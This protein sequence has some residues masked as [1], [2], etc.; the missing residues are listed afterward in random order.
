MN[1]CVCV[2]AI[3][4]SSVYMCV[5][6]RGEQYVRVCYTKESSVYVCVCVCV[7]CTEESSV[8]MCVCVTSANIWLRIISSNRIV[9]LAE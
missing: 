8:Y 5:L 6:Y 1:V 9:R 4:E 2:Y 3:K 7:C